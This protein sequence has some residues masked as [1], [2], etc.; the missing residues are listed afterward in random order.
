MKTAEPSPGEA[1]MT[2][3]MTANATDTEEGR[4]TCTHLGALGTVC[5]PM[6]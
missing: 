2:A 6:G 3:N 4:M 1:N 5:G